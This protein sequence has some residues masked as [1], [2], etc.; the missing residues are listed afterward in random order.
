MI[1]V[2]TDV[3]ID[4]VGKINSPEVA[5]VHQIPFTSDQKGLAA[6]VEKVNF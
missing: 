1:L 3:L 2:S 4:M 6:A 5:L